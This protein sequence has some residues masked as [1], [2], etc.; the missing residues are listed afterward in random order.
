MGL[1]YCYEGKASKAIMYFLRVSLLTLSGSNRQDLDMKSIY[2]DVLHM[3][4]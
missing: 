1:L 4:K 3:V 2:N